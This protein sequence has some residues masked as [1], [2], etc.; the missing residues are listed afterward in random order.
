M[1]EWLARRPLPLP[2]SNGTGHLLNGKGIGE[3]TD[4]DGYAKVVD[5]Y[6]LHV[7]PRLAEWEYAME[8]LKYEVDLLPD[9][10]SVRLI[11]V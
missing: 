11:N 9:M 1:E 4:D 7:L 10:R 2:V 3:D 6:C 8:F 5:V